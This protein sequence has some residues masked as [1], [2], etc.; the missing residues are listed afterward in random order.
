VIPIEENNLRGN[1]SESQLPDWP[2][3]AAKAIDDLSHMV[4][5]EIGL[6]EL[7]LKS[8]LQAR[9]DQALLTFFF[10]GLLLIAAVCFLA[11]TVLLFH[12]WME[13]WESFALTGLISALVAL[14][15]RTVS[16]RSSM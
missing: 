9:L 7:S 8:A 15:V 13:W 11:A 2:M 16:R 4:Q 6:A 5:A 3:L 10:T 1:P 12:R 14:L